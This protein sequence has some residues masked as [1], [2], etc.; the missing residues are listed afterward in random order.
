MNAA[1]FWGHLNALKQWKERSHTETLFYEQT[2]IFAA[3]GGQLEVLMWLNENGCSCDE[4]ICKAAARGGHLEVL[5]YAHEKV[6]PWDERTCSAAARGGHLDVL[7]YAHEQ[8]CS[9]DWR[10]CEAAR[11][12]YPELLEWAKSEGCPEREEDNS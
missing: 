3:L 4:G 6:C 11:G 10:T 9:W 1:A 12:V 5:K 7:K 8:G 2:C